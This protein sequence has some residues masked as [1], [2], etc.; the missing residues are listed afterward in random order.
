MAA[1]G[2]PALSLMPGPALEYTTLVGG[3][4]ARIPT[5]AL[6]KSEAKP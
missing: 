2:N 4:L 5:G 3:G 6:E 1:I